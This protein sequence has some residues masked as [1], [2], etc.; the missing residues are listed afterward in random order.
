MLQVRNSWGY[1]KSLGSNEVYWKPAGIH[2]ADLAVMQIYT[3]NFHGLLPGK[4]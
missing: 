3:E 2:L 1:R 4:C